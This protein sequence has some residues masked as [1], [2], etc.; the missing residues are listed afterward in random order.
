MDVFADIFFQH[1]VAHAP[2]IF[3][4]I[5]F[6]LCEIKTIFAIEVADGADGLGH[7]VEGGAGG[8]VDG[9]YGHFGQFT[10]ENH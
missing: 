7:D 9:R 3:G 2:R 8:S 5:Q 1:G 4:G 10:R 6:F